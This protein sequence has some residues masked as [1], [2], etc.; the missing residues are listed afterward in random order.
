MQEQVRSRDEKCQEQMGQIFAQ[1][2][3][4][5]QLKKRAGKDLEPKEGQKV[6]A[7]KEHVSFSN[8]QG[9]AL[10]RHITNTNTFLKKE[11]EGIEDKINQIKGSIN[12]QLGIFIEEDNESRTQDDEINHQ[13]L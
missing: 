5:M 11:V 9:V 1:I 3:E 2:Q 12:S 8:S 4:Q 6:D 13:Y 10:Q 7:F